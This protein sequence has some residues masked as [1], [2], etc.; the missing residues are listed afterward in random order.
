MDKEKENYHI[1]SWGEN[2]PEIVPSRNEV[3]RLLVE[4]PRSEQ[5]LNRTKLVDVRVEY[6]NEMGARYV[7][8]RGWIG[9]DGGECLAISKF[10]HSQN[11]EIGTA[12]GDLT[13][14][15]S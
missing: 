4:N 11:Y 8:V 3:I 1:L 7:R 9:T 13:I 12:I 2:Y 10:E 5:Q 15:R 14:Y 6:V